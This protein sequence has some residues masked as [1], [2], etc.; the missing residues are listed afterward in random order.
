MWKGKSVT[1]IL[2]TY[3]EKKSIYKAITEFGANEYVDEIIVVDNNAEAGTRGEVRKTRARL[4][5]ETRQGYGYAIR[6]GLAASHA[7]LLIVA[8]PDGSFDGRDVIKLLAYSDNFD[9]VFGSRTHQPLIHPGSDMTFYKRI[10]D[11]LLAKLVNILFL[12]Y[13]LTDLGCT[14]RL[15]KRRAWEEIEFECQSRDNIFATE[16]V[17]VAAKNRVRFIEIPINFRARVGL[18]TATSTVQKQLLWGFRKFICIWKIWG[19]ARA[20]T[21]LQ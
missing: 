18:S 20:Q 11:V 2:P 1:V 15:T 8:E 13:P 19:K 4:V 14:L 10:G 3:R 16:W 5:K 9:M 6:A 12:C 21:L 7:D 17:V